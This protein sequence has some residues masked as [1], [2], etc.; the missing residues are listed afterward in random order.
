MSRNRI[1]T[2]LRLRFSRLLDLTPNCT[3]VVTAHPLKCKVA[4]RHLQHS[5]DLAVQMPIQVEVLPYLAP[6]STSLKFLVSQS[7]LRFFFLTVL[8]DVSFCSSCSF[9]SIDGD[10]SLYICTSVRFSF[11]RLYQMLERYIVK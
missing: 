7:V 10:A 3:V 2:R 4:K 1:A 11:L 9:L 6:V 8:Q 5:C